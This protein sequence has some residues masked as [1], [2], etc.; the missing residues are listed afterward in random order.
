MSRGPSLTLDTNVAIAA[1]DESDAAAIELLDRCRAG[2]FT[3]AA[4]S[5]LEDEM[6][7]TPIPQWLKDLLGPYV[8]APARYGLST[9]GG[10]NLGEDQLDD[11]LL[12]VVG[13]DRPVLDNR[14]DALV[15]ERD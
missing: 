10:A 9:Y 15:L 7:K 13:H 4:T 5:R 6:T 3:V 1:V 12:L 8:G 14:R 11:L 2:D